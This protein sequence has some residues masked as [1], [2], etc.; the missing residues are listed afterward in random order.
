V[1][2]HYSPTSPYV[3]KVMVVA[4]EKGLADQIETVANSPW[5]END[6]SKVN[7]IRKIP[8]LVTDDG[9]ALFDSRVI[10]EY[11][12]DL[13][14]GDAL[15]PT[16]DERWNVLRMAAMGDGI[17]DAGVSISIE[18]RRDKKHWSDWHVGRQKEKINQTLDAL[19]TEAA[20]LNGAVDIGKITV[21]I[22]LG[23]IAFRGFIGDWTEGRPSLAAWYEKFAERPSMKATEHKE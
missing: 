8:A 15:F 5:D 9:V 11:L 7:P 21:A 3:R 1:K 4:H 13:G 10:C 2:L 18:G 19:E 22:A 14:N 6:L 12:D 16:G 17:L 20:G 23:Y